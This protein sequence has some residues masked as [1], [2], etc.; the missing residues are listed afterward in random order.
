MEPEKSF[1]AMTVSGK[2][3]WVDDWRKDMTDQE[4]IERYFN[5]HA[6]EFCRCADEIHGF[7][8]PSS[9]EYQSAAALEDLLESH[10]FQVERGLKDQPTAFRAVYGTGPVRI[11]YMCEYDALASLQQDDVPYQKGNGGFGHGC[12]HNLLGAGSAAAGIA[13]KNLIDEA[14]LPATVVVYGTPAEET[15]SGK[16]QMVAN[17]YFRDVDVCLGWHPL[18]H[19]DPGEVKFKAASAFLMKF[20]GRA[21]HACNCPENGQSALDAAELTNVGVNYLREHVNRDCYMHYCYTHGGDRPNIVP[22]SATLWYMVR[23]YTYREMVQLRERVQRIAQGACIMTD[24]TVEFE[25]LGENHDNKM[26]FTLAKLAYDCM[27]EIGAPIFSQED[28]DF[29]KEVAKNVGIEG[30]KGELDES[31]LPVDGTIKKDN[32]SSD[33]ADVSQIVPVV[34]INTA[35][36]GRKT[37]NHTWAVTV[38]AK[39]PAAHKGMIF[40]AKTLALM[41]AKLARDVKLMERVKEEFRQSEE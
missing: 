25:L 30:A 31:I 9:E 13:L 26:N 40:G 38:Q 35:C 36:Y 29:A 37:P 12:G 18:D 5:E 4:R 14:Q 19:N 21:A 24:T 2:L 28:K 23:A 10:G 1:R 8:E 34:N 15:L 3:T 17:G 22:E 6:E 32:G 39:H 27:V 7:A 33:I 20:H 16:T 11:G 41:G